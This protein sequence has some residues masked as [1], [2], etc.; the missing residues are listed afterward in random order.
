MNIVILGAGSKGSFL[1]KVLAREEHNIFLIDEDNEKLKKIA[2]EADIATILG[3]AT[4]WK[5]LDD[6]IDNNPSLFIAMTGDDNANL[7]ACEI[8]KNLGYPH[9]IAR[10]KDI[11]FLIKSRLDFAKMFLVDHFLAVEILTAHEIL[12]NIMNPEDLSIENFAHGAIQ[13]RT[14]EIPT[15]WK[16]S[17]IPLK[18]LELPNE[19]IIGLI[20]RKEN[21][22]EKIIF[23]S[24]DDY[25]LPLDEITVIGETKIMY[26]LHTIFDCVEKK[27]SSVLIAGGSDVAL[28][29]SR[30]LARINIDTKIIEVSKDRCN[31]LAELLPNTTILN[32]DATDMEFLE[33]L[34]MKNKDIFVACTS[35]DKKNILI[36]LLGKKLGCK[37]NLSLISDVTLIPLLRDL[38]I[39]H[40]LSEKVNL[41]NKII[42]LIHA[43][44]II[45]ATSLF[46]N[47]AKILEMRVSQESKLVGI[48][49]TDLRAFLPPKSIIAAIENKGRVMIGKG[50][51]IIS[52]N[53]T[54]IIV[55]DPE[56]INELQELF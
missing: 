17:F 44:K 50:D 28:C 42:S 47:Q 39:K 10:V 46:E 7:V 45:S 18:N 27:I 29:L 22:V 48:P 14:I 3:R 54:L 30:I 36:S 34:E 2:E 35:D 19:L 20:R 31:K 5:L 1:A 11:G 53:D 56:H 8:A 33:T 26:D 49:L 25:L 37:K 40:A 52:P 55:C 4:D 32:Q 38:D 6:L 16:K 9:T 51:R 15:T 13:M 43:T 23:P 21:A 12:K 41:T 24:G